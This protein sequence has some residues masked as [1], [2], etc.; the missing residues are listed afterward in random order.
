MKNVFGGIEGA[1]RPRGRLKAAEQATQTN[2]R[3]EVQE[4]WLLGNDGNLRPRAL[5]AELLGR[6]RNSAWGI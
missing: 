4:G 1:K 2:V 6:W 3:W 5:H